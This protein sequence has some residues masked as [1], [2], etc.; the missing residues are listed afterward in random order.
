MNE[1]TPVILRSFNLPHLPAIRGPAVE[2]LAQRAPR[3]LIE[4]A[5]LRD[6]DFSHLQCDAGGSVH[7]A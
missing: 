6:R 1:R 7:D 4:H 3:T 2:R 5:V